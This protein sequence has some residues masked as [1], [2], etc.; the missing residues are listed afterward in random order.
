MVDFNNITKYSSCANSK[1]ELNVVNRNIIDMMYLY[2]YAYINFS[3]ELSLLL[4]LI[5]I[6]LF[7]DIQSELCTRL[8]TICAY[9]RTL[10]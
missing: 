1:L 10:E 8:E 7:H 9:F 4:L 2:I 6:L 5:I 3:E